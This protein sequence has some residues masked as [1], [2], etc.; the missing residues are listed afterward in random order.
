MIGQNNSL[1][2]AGDFLKGRGAQV[3]THNPYLK[4]AYGTMI[5]YWD[6]TGHLLL[7]LAIITL[8]CMG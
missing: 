4:T 2:Q 1:A 6:G 5:N 8:Y 7:Y 3:N